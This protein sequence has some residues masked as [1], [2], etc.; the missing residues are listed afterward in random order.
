VKARLDELEKRP[1]LPQWTLDTELH[2][3]IRYRYENIT[4]DGSTT[5]DR[6]RVRARIG[7]YGKINE[8]VDYGVRLAAGTDSATSANETLGD[9]FIKDAAYF[10]LYYVDIHPGQFKGAH[11]LLGKMKKPW[12]KGS[13]LIW[14]G[15]TNPEG[16]AVKYSKPLEKTKL[17]AS[18]GSFVMED[19]KGDDTQLWTA[20]VAAETRL[21]NA[22][23]LAG[24]SLYRAENSGSGSG[25]PAGFNA[26][27]T[28]FNIVEGF[29][30]LST[31]IGKLPVKFH[32]QVAVNTEA[33]LDDDTAYLLGILLGKAKIPGS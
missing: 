5:K 24:A 9:K 10:D 15:D 12:F 1:K 26:P 20:Q 33:E 27:D 6:Q 21:E 8:Y 29:G 16:I 28:A 2:G 7:A 3:D 4:V 22:E 31:K 30:A 14:D 23:I 19:N 17:I 18:A 32:G 11:V 25:L 13:G